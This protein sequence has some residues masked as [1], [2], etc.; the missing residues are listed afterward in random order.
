MA[1]FSILAS[2]AILLS[3]APYAS[4]QSGRFPNLILKADC[5]SNPPCGHG[6]ERLTLRSPD[7]ERHQ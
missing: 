5:F 3:P 7:R 1:L 4:A 2:F 6:H